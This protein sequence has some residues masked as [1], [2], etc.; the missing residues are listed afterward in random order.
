MSVHY[1][2]RYLLRDD[3][4]AG[5]TLLK[6]YPNQTREYRQYRSAVKRIAKKLTRFC[7]YHFEDV[8]QEAQMR[9]LTQVQC[10]KFISAFF[11]RAFRAQGGR[12]NAAEPH[13]FEILEVPKVIQ[14]RAARLYP[15]EPLRPQYERVCFHPQYV[16]LA[17]SA[18]LLTY[19]H[20]L[21]SV[22]IDLALGAAGVS[23]DTLQA[24]YKWATKTAQNR[25]IDYIR[26]VHR[27]QT[28]QTIFPDDSESLRD[29]RDPDSIADLEDYIRELVETLDRKYP[30][31]QYLQLWRE[32]DAGKTQRQIAI[33]SGISQA[34]I[35]KRK[36]ELKFYVMEWLGLISAEAAIDKR[37]AIRGSGRVERSDKDY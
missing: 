7:P 36:Q 3:L 26:A 18:L 12:I 29:D 25:I 6:P 32:L 8:V 22:T 33:E 28:N 4:R 1:L 19:T 16:N 23:D 14:R 27:E 30:R 34:E 11:C 5:A 37:D 10:A 15:E 24:F 13:L 17:P 20:P 35:N 2:E 9:V 31:K 21:R